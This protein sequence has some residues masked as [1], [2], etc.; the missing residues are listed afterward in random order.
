MTVTQSMTRWTVNSTGVTDDV[1]W[2]LTRKVWR[3]EIQ[4]ATG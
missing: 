3:E 4:T 2:N 1:I